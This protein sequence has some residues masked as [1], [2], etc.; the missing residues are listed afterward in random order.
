MRQTSSN[1][2]AH[3]PEGR[4]FQV[5]EQPV[6]LPL[7][8]LCGRCDAVFPA[9]DL[10]FKWG[11]NSET[12]ITT[13]SSDAPLSIP[14]DD[15]CYFFD[16]IHLVRT[17]IRQAGV[18]EP[19][20]TYLTAATAPLTYVNCH[21][22]SQY[23]GSTRKTPQD[24]LDGTSTT[25]DIPNL[26]WFLFYCKSIDS[27]SGDVPASQAEVDLSL[28]TSVAL[29]TDSS[30]EENDSSDPDGP[31]PNIAGWI[32]ALVRR[33]VLG[34]FPPS[35]QFNPYALYKLPQPT[36]SEQACFLCRDRNLWELA[37]NPLNLPPHTIQTIPVGP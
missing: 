28:I 4:S 7:Q 13:G 25:N 9:F 15:W 14:R 23:F 3:G 37:F 36:F 33:R 18:F 31:G 21:W 6:W 10:L 19:G 17:P 29:S 35:V 30:V 32:L 22:A 8:A 27:I 20:E 16:S 24:V 26:Q 2:I 5:A 11:S 1:P 12:K 34:T